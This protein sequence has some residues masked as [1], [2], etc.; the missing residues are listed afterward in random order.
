MFSATGRDEDYVNRPGGR[1]RGVGLWLL[2]IFVLA[3]MVGFIIWA[4][5]F[6]IE[7]VGN[8]R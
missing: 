3:A 2:L 5:L 1:D 4:A 7:E 6:E 8:R